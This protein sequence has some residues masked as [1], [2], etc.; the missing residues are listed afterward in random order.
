[1]PLHEADILKSH[2]NPSS[3]CCQTVRTS[4]RSKKNSKSK[5]KKL[6]LKET[7]PKAAN[8]VKVLKSAFINKATN[9][10]KLDKELTKIKK[11]PASGIIFNDVQAHI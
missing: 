10:M 8:F 2:G 5:I 7:Q 9:K 6:K 11:A 1:M 3:E 4:N